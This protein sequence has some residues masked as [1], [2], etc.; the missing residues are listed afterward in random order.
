ML[1]DTLGLVLVVHSQPAREQ[2][3]R[4]VG[5]VLGAASPTCA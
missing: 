1:V 4:G 3:R 5:P 2:D